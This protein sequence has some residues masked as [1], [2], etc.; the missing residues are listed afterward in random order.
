MATQT[1]EF[2]AGTGLTISCKLFAIGSDTVVATATATEKTNDDNRYAVEFTD[3]AAGAYRLNGFVSSVGGFAN[4][5]Y[6][7]T[8]ETATFYPRSET[9]M[10]GTDA[11][12][13]AANYTAPANSDITSIK[14]KTDQLAFTVAN[15]V[16]SNALS[17]GGSGLDAAGVRAAVGLASANLDTQLGDIPTNAEFEARSIP[18]AD[19]FVVGDYTAPLDAS[20]VRS[21]VGLATAN[22]DTQL[23][24]LPTVAE[25]D[26]RTLVAADYFVVSDYTTPPTASSVADEVQTRTIARVTLVDTCT[27]NTDM[28]GTDSAALAATALSTATWTGTLATN[29]GTT[30]TTVATNLDA[31]VSS[32][33]ALA[34][35]TAPLTSEQTQTAAAAALTAYDPPTRTE[36]T[37]DKDAV[38]SAIS[39][40]KSTPDKIAVRS[41]DDTTPVRFAWPTSGETITVERSLN[42]A[43]YEAATGTVA[44]F[45]T[46]GTEHWYT[47]SYN[48]ADRAVGV[49]R[50]RL[51]DGTITRYVTLRV[52]LPTLTAANVWEHATR[53]LTTFGTL[54]SDIWSAGTRTLTAISDSSGVTTLLGRIAGTIRTSADDVSAETAQTAAIRSG[55]ALEAT[56][57]DIKGAGFA[58]GTDSLEAISDAIAGTSGSLTVEQ[59]AQLTAIKAKTDLITS[60][61][62]NQ[63]RTPVN[64]FAITRGDTFTGTQAVTTNYTGYTATFTI[65]HRITDAVLCTA[66]ATVTS[67]TVLTVALTTTNTAFALLVDPAEFGPHPYDIRLVNGAI[68]KT[69]RGIAVISRDMTRA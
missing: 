48:A 53:S 4:E 55:L 20:G 51:N 34:S 6:D 59:A 5:I 46:E 12:L 8:L 66:S 27:T 54:V 40:A 25:F 1:L 33:L 45:R 24:D 35:Y 18:S 10:R 15:Q 56:L 44:F 49:V 64:T 16:D 2:N 38:L 36:A 19:Y 32:R 28:R 9:K 65:R 13:L 23:A 61:T 39:G 3:V 26:A 69:E 21:A 47:L 37:A 62:A 50:Y 60:Q 42:N 67:S 14:T 11:S 52:E 29:L 7:L 41:S 30:N 22:L 68:E 43:A 31:T 17:G 57:T 58:T 63:T